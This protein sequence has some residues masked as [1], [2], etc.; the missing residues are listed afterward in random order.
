MSVIVVDVV[1]IL[2]FFVCLFFIYLFGVSVGLMARKIGDRG[3]T[4]NI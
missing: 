1:F 4:G 3:G 2:G